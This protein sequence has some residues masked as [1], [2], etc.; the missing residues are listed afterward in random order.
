LKPQE[1]VIAAHKTGEFH[2]SF[3]SPKVDSFIAEL[4]GEAQVAQ[5]PKKPISAFQG[6]VFPPMKL[7]LLADT[8]KP[9]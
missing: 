8:V 3:H 9:Q 2:L 5:D 4:L 6:V 7:Q 1:L